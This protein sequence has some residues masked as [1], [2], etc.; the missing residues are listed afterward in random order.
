MSLFGFYELIWVFLL[1]TISLVY[2]CNVSLLQPNLWHSEGGG[3]GE[4]GGGAPKIDRNYFTIPK[5]YFNMS[6]WRRSARTGPAAW[7]APGAWGHP[8]HRWQAP[9][10]RNRGRWTETENIYHSHL[11][12]LASYQVPHL[13]GP[14]AVAREDEPPWP[15]PHPTTP[16]ALVNTEAGDDGPIHRPGAQK[17]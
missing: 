6:T 4:A 15:G 8:P 13:D 11:K 7:S 16:L 2:K 10:G 9:C 5:I 3:G 14:L 12:Y 17:C 1:I